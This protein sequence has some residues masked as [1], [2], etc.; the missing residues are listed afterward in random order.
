MAVKVPT[1]YLLCGSATAAKAALVESVKGEF[2][3]E[4]ISV[5]GV[6]S[7]RGYAPGDPRID[8]SVIAAAV[9]VILFEIITAGMSDQ[10]LAIDDSLGDQ[11]VTDKYIANANGAGMKVKLLS[12]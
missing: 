1:L 5:E 3:V 2:G 8:N 11:S 4:V 10:S 12:S 6:S 7:R 9:D